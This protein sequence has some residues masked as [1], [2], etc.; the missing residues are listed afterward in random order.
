MVYRIVEKKK[1]LFFLGLLLILLVIGGILFLLGPEKKQPQVTRPPQKEKPVS[2]EASF[3]A[4]SSEGVEAIMTATSGMKIAQIKDW[5]AFCDKQGEKAQQCKESFYNQISDEKK[6]KELCERIKDPDL[7]QRCLKEAGAGAEARGAE[8]E[9]KICDRVADKKLK[10]V[11]GQ[12]DTLFSSIGQREPTNKECQTLE[13]KAAQ[14][15]CF[16]VV[17]NKDKIDVTITDAYQEICGDIQ[18]SEIQDVCNTL[19]QQIKKES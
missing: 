14:E 8:K 10:A 15:I 18:D 17:R 4:V 6:D 1:A 16:S 11:C 19:F 5:E 2:D 12:L 9:E 13:N 7:R 3:L